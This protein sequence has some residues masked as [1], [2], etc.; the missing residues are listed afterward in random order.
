MAT[1]CVR[2]VHD[3]QAAE[4]EALFEGVAVKN[5]HFQCIP[6]IFSGG[7]TTKR[8]FTVSSTFNVRLCYDAPPATTTKKPDSSAPNQEVK[9]VRFKQTKKPKERQAKGKE[10]TSKTA[11]N[12]NAWD[13]FFRKTPKRKRNVGGA[14]ASPCTSPVEK[15]RKGTLSDNLATILKPLELQPFVSP[16]APAAARKQAVTYPV[17][18]HAFRY[19]P[20]DSGVEV[21]PF[22]RL[23][24]AYGLMAFPKACKT[25]HAKA[26]LN[27]AKES[28]RPG[29]RRYNATPRKYQREAMD[30]VLNKLRT[31][32]C[33]S[34][35]LSAGCGAGKTCCGLF[36]AH[37]LGFPT[38][39]LV[40]TDILFKQWIERGA[41]FLPD[42][43]IDYLR[44]SHR[45]APDA[46]ICVVMLQTLMNIPRSEA[47]FLKR[48]GLLLVDE[49]HHICCRTFS[50][51]LRKCRAPYVL[52]LSATLA[53]TDK[54]DGAIEWLI[55]PPL[56]YLYRK[57][58]EVEVQVINYVNRRFRPATRRWDAT[59]VDYVKTISLL[60]D[61]EYRT[62]CLAKKVKEAAAEGRRVIVISDRIRL[63]TD[64][65]ELIPEAGLLVGGATTK[66]KK[67]RNA[68]ALTKMIILAS[69]G[70]AS[71]GLDVP[72]LDT[73]FIVL[74]KKNGPNL[75]QCVGRIL[76]GHSMMVPRIYHIVDG[77][78]MFRGM[79]RG[80][81]K[82]YEQ[83]G[84]TFLPVVTEV[85]VF[86]RGPGTLVE[87]VDE[88]F[89][90][91]VGPGQVALRP[92]QE[93]PDDEP[94]QEMMEAMQAY[95]RK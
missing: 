3:P 7:G 12:K 83:C 45:P 26:L 38:L 51:A 36:A 8:T 1:K 76:R 48:Y 90:V 65:L 21:E 20:A 42:A 4:A 82:Y 56:Y 54:L 35:L 5:P 63:L 29:L 93:A 44:G 87:N 79:A 95:T 58:Q 53:R 15:K 62:A 11:T 80:C 91:R 85:R 60:V 49:C 19:A 46:D 71:E 72:T 47:G 84:Y 66:A 28:D 59:A 68:E 32:R 18:E 9:T 2:L 23:P 69:T 40:H 34:G 39:I 24:R 17:F 16:N 52:G 55:G 74:P 31:L 61:D 86:A 14:L 73:V 50:L 43:K 41:M 30:H 88:E 10:K 33:H 13:L 25:W 81:Q 67:A 6:P 92:D 64:L 22:Y 77:Y 70:I 89:Y 57:A 94:P 27:L 78:G 37:A 75:E